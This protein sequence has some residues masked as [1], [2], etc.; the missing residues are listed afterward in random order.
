[1]PR[2]ATAGDWAILLILTA[3]WGTS[4]AFTKIALTVFPPSVLATGR[5][6]VAALV[7]FTYMRLKGVTLPR[8][9][10]EWRPMLITA[11]FGNLIPFHLISSAQTRID[12]SVAA[13]LMA[14]MPLFVLTLAQRYVPGFAFGF[15]G[16][17]L[18][19][20]PENLTS[21]SG[22]DSLLGAAAMLTAAFSYAANSIYARTLGP[23]NPVS[24]SVGMLL[25]SSS[26]SLPIAA[27]DL[28]SIGT[29][30]LP[31]ALSLLILGLLSTGVA[32]R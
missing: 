20:G 5:I 15:T 9:L 19:V 1:M 21:L 25:L 29:V 28:T 17:L 23:I 2:A 12:S 4:F 31:A 7:L 11:L 10:Q 32:C 16:V 27:G 22:N 13:V 30:S 24:L 18:V 26:M 8:R 3:F 14:V 6:L